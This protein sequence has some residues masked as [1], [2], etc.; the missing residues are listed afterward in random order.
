MLIAALGKQKKLN[1]A[2]VRDI[3]DATAPYRTK[4]QGHLLNGLLF[5]ELQPKTAEQH[6]SFSRFLQQA[7]P[8]SNNDRPFF[9]FIFFF[10]G[11]S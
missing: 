5:K 3:Y 8:L 4:T 11:H 10:S 6:A 7:Q 2:F 9:L 1:D